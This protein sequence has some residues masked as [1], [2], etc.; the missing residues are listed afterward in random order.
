MSVSHR[1]QTTIQVFGKMFQDV[2]DAVGFLSCTWLVFDYISLLGKILQDSSRLS[3]SDA[4][5][6]CHSLL[7]ERSSRIHIRRTAV[8]L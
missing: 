2:K 5:N 6:D 7:V 1:T 4:P 8:H 3:L